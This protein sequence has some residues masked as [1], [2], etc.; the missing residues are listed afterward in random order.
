MSM[1]RR[2]PVQNSNSK[3][4]EEKEEIG[5]RR[6]KYATSKA[7]KEIGIRQRL[8]QSNPSSKD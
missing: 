8:R 7:V 5:K 4:P 6:M 3:F 2:T 1:K